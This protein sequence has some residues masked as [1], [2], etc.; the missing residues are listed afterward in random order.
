MSQPV[1]INF[2][3]VTPSD[4][5]AISKTA[6]LYVGGAGNIVVVGVNSAAVTF[7]NVPAGTLIP[8]SVTFVKA[9]GTT[10]TNIVALR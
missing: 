8:L 5:A 9:T 6:A 10:A 1:Y 4:T 7:Y 3:A 2:V